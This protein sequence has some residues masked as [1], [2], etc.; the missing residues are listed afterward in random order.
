M[1]SPIVFWPACQW[2]DVRCVWSLDG[3]RSLPLPDVYAGFPWRLSAGNGLPEH[4]SP[5][6]DERNSPHYQRLEL[7]LLREFYLCTLMNKCIGTST[8]YKHTLCYC[9][10][11]YHR[12]VCIVEAHIS[13]SVSIC[14]RISFRITF[15]L[16]LHGTKGCSKHI[17]KYNIIYKHIE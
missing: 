12:T 16:I 5:A 10:S 4:R 1:C 6:G 11:T 8:D 17:K 14:S 15:Y 9:R 7:L 2:R 3:G 13:S